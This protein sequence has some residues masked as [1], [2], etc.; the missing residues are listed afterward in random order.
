[1][2]LTH[3]ADPN[4]CRV[5]GASA[6]W[7][8][9]Q[10]GHD[11]IVR[12]LLKNGAR[13]DAVRCVRKFIIWSWS[14]NFYTWNRLL[15]GWCHTTIQ[16]RTQR[17]LRRRPWTAQTQTESVLIGGEWNGLKSINSTK[18]I[19]ISIAEWWDG[20]A[21]SRYVWTFTRGKAIDSGWQWYSLEKSGWSDATASGTTTEFY[22][23]GRI[24]WGSSQSNVLT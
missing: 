3:G 22:I 1:M 24:S 14:C 7:I 15:P 10:M 13:V 20:T 2:L 11:H 12:I 16:G 5:D 8:A 23:C 6:L 21:R 9:A 17:I 19:S 18:N 4:V